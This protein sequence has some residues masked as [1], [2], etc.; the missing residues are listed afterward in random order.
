MVSI[1]SNHIHND[2]HYNK[3]KINTNNNIISSFT[4]AFIFING[5]IVVP[6]LILNI[7]IIVTNTILTVIMANIA[8]MIING[9]G[10]PI[11]FTMM[12]TIMVNMIRHAVFIFMIG[13]IAAQCTSSISSISQ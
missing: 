2:G 12:A 10:A 7:I 4:D 3:I 11:S 9:I 5:M 8:F 1:A 6:S 13:M